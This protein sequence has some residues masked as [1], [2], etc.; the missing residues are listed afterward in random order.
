MTALLTLT[1]HARIGRLA[2]V[3][4]ALV[5]GIVAFTAPAVTEAAGTAPTAGASEN[6]VFMLLALAFGVVVGAVT[7]AGM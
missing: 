1:A 6:F 4:A 3:A 2:L 5:I 7:M